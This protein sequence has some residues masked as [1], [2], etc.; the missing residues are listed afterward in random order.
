MYELVCNTLALSLL[1]GNA[2]SYSV[3]FPFPS[4][5]LF[6]YKKIKHVKV[7]GTLIGAM[8]EIWPQ[9]KRR[10]AGSALSS[11]CVGTEFHF[12]SCKNSSP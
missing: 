9:T 4:I 12:A 10:I 1:L 2:A 5:T 3:M 6:L 8:Y 7:I 11:Q